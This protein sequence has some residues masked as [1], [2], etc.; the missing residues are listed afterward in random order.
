MLRR[1]SGPP[2]RT[3]P[4]CPTSCLATVTPLKATISRRPMTA[5]AN[6]AMRRARWRGIERNGQG[7][8]SRDWGRRC[9]PAIIAARGPAGERGC[10][11][12]ETD[13]RSIADHDRTRAATACRGAPGAV[14]SAH[15]V[16][17]E[18]EMA[19]HRRP[20]RRPL[21]EPRGRRLHVRAGRLPRQRRG[22]GDGCARDE[23]GARHA[24]RGAGVAT[25]AARGVRRLERFER[26][27]AHGRRGRRGAAPGRGARQRSR[28]VRT[29]LRHGGPERAALGAERARARGARVDGDRRRP[30]PSRPGARRPARRRRLV[31]ASRRRRRPRAALPVRLRRG[32]RPRAVE[33]GGGAG[34]ARRGRAGRTT[35]GSRTPTTT[36]AAVAADAGAGGTASG[37]A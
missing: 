37:R 34:P 17:H 32:A 36:A 24:A 26:R 21:P 2:L 25:R 13:R 9:T 35:G 29:A 18:D 3:T 7:R 23:P 22:P 20:A 5:S 6:V 1:S 19:G 31:A 16:Q 15:G 14:P 27:A 33:P 28:P 10:R 8:G 4:T 11:S 12:G 30:R